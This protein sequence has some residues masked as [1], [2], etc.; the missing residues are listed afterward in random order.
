MKFDYNLSTGDA[1][2]KKTKE[3]CDTG[4]IKVIDSQKTNKK[5]KPIKMN[6]FQMGN[7]AFK[8]PNMKEEINY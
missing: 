3:N 7:T 4:E 2:Y 6:S 1:T 5:V 8:F